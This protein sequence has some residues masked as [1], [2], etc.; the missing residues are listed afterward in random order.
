MR[1]GASKIALERQA[2]GYSQQG[3]AAQIRITPGYLC[4]VERRRTV[5][6]ATMRRKIIEALGG[7][8][9]DFFDVTTG[10]AI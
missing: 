10:L 7:Q 6:G 2:L 1:K 9:N 4:A 8:E 3:L 5:A